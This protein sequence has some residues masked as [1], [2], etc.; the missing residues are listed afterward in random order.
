MVG[1]SVAY[2]DRFLMGITRNAIEIHRIDL[3]RLQILLGI[4]QP[5]AFTDKDIE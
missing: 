3:F 4:V 1:G 2:W 5:D